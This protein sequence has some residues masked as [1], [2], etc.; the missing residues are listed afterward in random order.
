MARNYSALGTSPTGSTGGVATGSDKPPNRRKQIL[1]TAAAF[2]VIVV[3]IGIIAASCGGGGSDNAGDGVGSTTKAA[4]RSAHGPTE[5]VDGVPR[6]YTH[7]QTGATTAAVNFIQAVSQS[8]QGRITGDKLRAQAVAASPTPGLVSVITGSANRTESDSG[9]FNTMPVVTTV[10]SYDPTKAVVSVWAL[11][12]SQSK[13][14][15][16]AKVALQ[17][18]WST[19]TVTVTWEGEDWKA[20]DWQYQTGPDP[21]TQMF[22]EANSPLAQ[23]GIG[24]FYTFYVD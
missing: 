21:D 18:L 14:N 17:T 15:A 23:K 24:G 8:D 3:V 1:V 10:R 5:V 11:G 20:S 16:N 4:I 9:V 7:D 2:V 13:V 22:P 19:T 6:G 12:A